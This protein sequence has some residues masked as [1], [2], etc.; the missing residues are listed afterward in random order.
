[1]PKSET[2]HFVIDGTLEDDTIVFTTANRYSFN[3]TS[4]TV[5]KALVAAGVVIN[6]GLGNDTLTGWSGPDHL[7]GGEGNDTLTGGGGDDIL[8]GGAG[9]DTLRGGAGND[10]LIDADWLGG[11]FDGGR[12]TDTLDLSL[13]DAT[14]GVA[15]E[16]ASGNVF[17]YFRFEANG[18]VTFAPGPPGEATQV[19]R[20]RDVENV[21]GSAGADFLRGTVFDNR[22]EGG[23][24]R[25]TIDGFP[26]NDSL[27]GG[28]DADR[29]SGGNGND[30]IFGGL[31]DD[32]ITG[33]PGN[34]QL[35]GDGGADRFTYLPGDGQ[36]V[37]FDFNKLEGDTIAWFGT[38]KSITLSTTTFNGLANTVVGTFSDGTSIVFAG[39]TN[40]DDVAVTY[41]VA[42]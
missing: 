41:P 23:A 39:I 24:G 31:G 26:G 17:P 36:D 16:L 12:G 13:S 15:L 27:F 10:T 35:H 34:D 25:D 1:M 4:R 2:G 11:F 18:D 14:R 29:I 28:A 21:I 32:A 5:D 19:V 37:I 22:I 30:T 42:G 33:G 38:E 8:S 3:G 6:G 20:I 40:F 9:Y 7:N